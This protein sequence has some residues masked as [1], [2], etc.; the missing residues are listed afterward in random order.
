MR[1]S[2][3]GVAFVAIIGGI[4]AAGSTPVGATARMQMHQA[5]VRLAGTVN[6]ASLPAATGHTAG[7]GALRQQPYRTSPGNSSGGAAAIAAAAPQIQQLSIAA[8]IKLNPALKD[9]DNTSGLTPPDMAVG[10][11]K[12]H[13]VQMV[14]VVG[15][16]WT[17]HVAGTAFQLSSFFLA[18][19]D[20]ISDPWVLFDQ[21]SGHWFA[22]IGDFTLAGEDIAVS[23][24]GN[25]TGSWFIYQIQYPGQT[26]GGCPDQ[27]K[28]GVDTNV[29]GL[30]FNEFAGV[31]C[32]GGF[33]GAGLEV[34]NKSQ[35]IA[36][37]SVNF[38]Y[39]NPIGSYFSLVP[40]Q[41]LSAGATTLYFA[42]HDMNNTSKLLH[43]VTSVGVPTPTT[44]ITLT[45]LADLTLAHTY[46][47]PPQAPQPGTSSLLNSGDQ[48][49]Q[50]VVWKAGVGL[51]MTW[52][53]ACKPAGDTVKRDCGR[54]VATN[55]GVGGP[56]V[57]MDK[58]LSKNAKYYVYPAATLNSAND[59]VADFEVT[60]STIFPQL[61][62][63]SAHV[64]LAF[65]TTL[66]LVPGTTGNATGRYGDYSAVA[67]DPGGTTP[68]QNVWAA[69]EI[70]GPN[71][72]DWQTGVREVKVTP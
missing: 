63:A 65:G 16:I 57:I 70:G 33:L 61:D 1:R 11:D 64:G 51:L 67:L 49:M 44:S 3:L 10:A 6:V 50:H 68:N 2:V 9:T 41:A 20:F 35:M 23:A 18:G 59:V 15:K 53:E 36:G 25:P 30:G 29:L 48:R 5:S 31:G 37:A 26:G 40:A 38:V 32:T 69:G 72:G 17:N 24:T 14:N 43:R 46:A 66:V 39:T 71:T 58:E 55:D 60:S 4:F 8:G 54:V 13:V 21:D 22:G 62:A 12:T 28:G 52:T 34:F 7:S 47:A 19:S 27:G 42:S 45:A 56:A